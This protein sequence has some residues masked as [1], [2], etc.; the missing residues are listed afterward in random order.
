MVQNIGNGRK[1]TGVFVADLT[2]DQVKELYAV[3]TFKF[4]DISYNS[5]Y[6]HTRSLLTSPPELTRKRRGKV[7]EGGGGWGIIM[8][9]CAGVVAHSA[10]GR[11]VPQTCAGQDANVR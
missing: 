6:R 5:R 1:K 2:L 4:R 3:Q 9:L 7:G 11:Q 10:G 8:L